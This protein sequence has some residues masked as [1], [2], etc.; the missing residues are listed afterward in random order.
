DRGYVG[1][2][3]DAKDSEYGVPGFSMQNLSFGSNYKDGL[4]VGVVIKQ[5]RYALE[6]LLRDPLP[7][8]ERAELRASRL[9][10]TS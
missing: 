2:S 1:V 9:D 4:P 5:Q 7:G 10:N 8:F 6:A 3:I